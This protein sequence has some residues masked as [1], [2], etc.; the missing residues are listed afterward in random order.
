MQPDQRIDGCR[1]KRAF[2]SA[3][4]EDVRVKIIPQ[5]FDQKKSMADI[6]GIDFRRIQPALPQIIGRGDEPSWYPGR[7]GL[8]PCRSAPLVREPGAHDGRGIL[9]GVA[10]ADW[11]QMNPEDRP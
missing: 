6:G 8:V 1:V 7:R 10:R 5:I 4:A 11:R 2:I 9:R 3:I